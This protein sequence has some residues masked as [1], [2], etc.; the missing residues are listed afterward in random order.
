MMEQVT[1]TVQLKE[2]DLVNKY[3]EL[4]WILLNVLQYQDDNVAYPISVLG[5]TRTD[6]PVEPASHYKGLWFQK[7]LLC[8]D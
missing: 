5:W 2:Q 7:V 4:G 6:E 1:K 8:L 3:L